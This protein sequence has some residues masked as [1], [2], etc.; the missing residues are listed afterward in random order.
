[1]KQF[2]CTCVR[3]G[4][5]LCCLFLPLSGFGQSAMILPGERWLRVDATARTLSVMRGQNVEVRF[6]D[7][8][9]G[10]LG[11]KPVHYRGDTS[12]PI[13]EFR[14]DAINRQSNY[15]LFF[16]LNYPTVAHA[17]QALAAGRISQQDHERIALAEWQGRAPPQDTPL[18]G[19]IGIHGIGRG[20]LKVHRTYNWTEGCVALDNQQIHAL[21][22]YVRVGM[23]VLIEE[24]G[25]AVPA[26][27][28]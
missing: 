12:T 24:G 19:M 11:P 1:M 22:A 25:A 3:I 15:T 14:I 6:D 17:T 13:G 5:L 26:P 9:L 18:G 28:P 10:R 7:I 27:Q 8:S 20:S 2:H 4:L 16:R 21:A 23:R